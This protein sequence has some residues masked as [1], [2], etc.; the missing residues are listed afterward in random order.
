MPSYGPSLIDEWI[1]QPQGSGITRGSD[2]HDHFDSSSLKTLSTVHALVLGTGDSI[3]KEILPSIG[4]AQY[5]VLF[6]T[7]FWA[8][9]SS[10]SQVSSC[11]KNLSAAAIQR[12]SKIKVRICLSSLSLLQK[13][14]HT[15]SPAGH[16]YPSSVWVQKFGLPP[17]EDLNGLDLEIKSIFIRPFSVMHPKFVIVD[18]RYLYLPSCNV[19]WENWFE[20]CLQISGPIVN[21]FLEFWRDFWASHSDKAS[22]NFAVQSRNEMGDVPAAF[23]TKGFQ[24]PSSQ[25]YM[26]SITSKKFQINL[27]GIQS[28]FLLSSHRT[29]PQFRPFPWQSAAR[30]PQTPLNVF[31]L[32]AFNNAKSSIY[33]QTPNVT[34]PPVLEALLAALGRGVD[35]HIITS[36]R[37][38]I[39]EQLITAGT[40]TTRCL[41]QLKRQFITLLTERQKRL[42]DEEQGSNSHIGSLKIEYFIKRSSDNGL[43]LGPEPVQTHLKL[44]IVDEATVIFGSGNM[45]RASWYTS[46]ELGVAYVSAS[47][48]QSIMSG[49]ES[50]L[51][52]RKKLDF[53]RTGE[54]SES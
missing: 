28:A 3:F 2:M 11:L 34:S 54:L 37:L 31:L 17:S 8:G 13:L 47:L 39:L 29:N 33:V 22:D 41:K 50:C 23:N 26:S 12:G 40:S 38:M 14:F 20:G 35:V 32:H 1:A 15:S 48:V 43:Q 6:V 9:S 52:S 21:H 5:E 7:C 4:Q 45:D 49:L 30:P 19:S 16:V 18:R 51:M 46:Q 10:L 27:S 42:M 36:E 25:A 24:P 53:C 44:T